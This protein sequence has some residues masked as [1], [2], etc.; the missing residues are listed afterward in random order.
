MEEGGQGR[1]NVS[2]VSLDCRHRYLVQNEQTGR[3]ECDGGGRTSSKPDNQL[4]PLPRHRNPEVSERAGQIARLL[5]K[6]RGRR[7]MS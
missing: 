1:F 4:R 7:R 5:V 2:L 6:I 3:F